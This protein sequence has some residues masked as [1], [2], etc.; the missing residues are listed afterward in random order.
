MKR[1]LP[2][3]PIVIFTLYKSAELELQALGVKALVGKEESVIKL[4]SRLSV[5]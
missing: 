1:K 2:E 4:L 5:G 3:T